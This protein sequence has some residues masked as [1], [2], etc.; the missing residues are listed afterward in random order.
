MG[1]NQ[2]TSEKDNRGENHGK[3]PLILIECNHDKNTADRE[4]NNPEH[5][6]KLPCQ[7]LIFYKIGSGILFGIPGGHIYCL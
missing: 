5:H 4:Q 1:K 2:G 3:K 7:S 6:P